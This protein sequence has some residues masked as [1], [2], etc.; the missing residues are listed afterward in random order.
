MKRLHGKV[1]RPVDRELRFAPWLMPYDT[2]V[3]A[4][5]RVIYAVAQLRY[6]RRY[7]HARLQIDRTD[8]HVAFAL[9][10]SEESASGG[11]EDD[12][13]VLRDDMVD[14]GQV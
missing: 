3:Q 9:I 8:D 11:R 12:G 1:R 7:A 2:A 14:D 13:V 5:T 4:V 6:G 10:V